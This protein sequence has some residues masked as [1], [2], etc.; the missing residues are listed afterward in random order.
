MGATIRQATA[1]V[2]NTIG[3]FKYDTDDLDIRDMAK[4]SRAVEQIIE[5]KL[6]M[7]GIITQLSHLVLTTRYQVVKMEQYILKREQG[8]ADSVRLE[9]CMPQVKI[10]N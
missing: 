10:H 9:G 4:D 7:A 5:P 2:Y 8:V 3:K 1:K 6:D